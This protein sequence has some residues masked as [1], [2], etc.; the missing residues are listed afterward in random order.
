MQ[1]K[2]QP[3]IPPQQI[4][5]EVSKL[6]GA[7]INELPK[8]RD[9]QAHKYHRHRI[10]KIYEAFSKDEQ[11]QFD[12][13]LCALILNELDKGIKGAKPYLTDKGGSAAEASN[14]I[15]ESL[16]L[17]SF[18]L[19]CSSPKIGFLGDTPKNMWAQL[20]HDFIGNYSLIGHNCEHASLSDESSINKPAVNRSADFCSA[21]LSAQRPLLLLGDTHRV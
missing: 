4:Y 6:L 5:A 10:K 8:S 17:L 15:K 7:A 18:F 19:D 13:R 1:T 21:A 3:E 11:D 14:S 20:E 9:E 12:I 16:R 2:H